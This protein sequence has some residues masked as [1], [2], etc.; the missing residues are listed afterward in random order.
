MA[1]VTA[2]APGR[3]A[4]RDWARKYPPLVAVLLALALAALVLPSA[5]H[6]PQSNPQTTLEYAP[7]P[8]S[9][10]KTPPPANGNLSSLGLAGSSSF[11]G[12]GP[13][14]DEGLGADNSLL[15]GN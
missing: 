11:T 15:G 8:P 4:S 6:V 7:V 13:G 1:S 3:G 14:G 5:L 10:E 12:A 9:D 2:D